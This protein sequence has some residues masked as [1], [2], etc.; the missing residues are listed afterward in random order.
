M[1][2]KEPTYCVQK[3]VATDG[4]PRASD[5]GA[6]KVFAKKRAEMLKKVRLCNSPVA[7]MLDGIHLNP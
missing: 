3:F 2:V 1:D 6:V 4:L 7:Y 5:F